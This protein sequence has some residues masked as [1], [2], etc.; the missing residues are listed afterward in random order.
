[1]VRWVLIGV[2]RATA[3]CTVDIDAKGKITGMG[4]GWIFTPDSDVTVDVADTDYLHY[5][6]WLKKTT[7]EDGVVTYNEVETFAGSSIPASEDTELASV[8]GS[9]TYS[10]GATGVY[11][12]EMLNAA[13]NIDSATSGHFTADVALTAYFWSD[14]QLETDPGG[15]CWLIRLL[16]VEP[17]PPAC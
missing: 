9:A 13:G 7:D 3:V 17:S 1:M 4:D 6:V 15:T 12:H 10:G 14:R 11:V 8:K 16:P 2:Q 5:G